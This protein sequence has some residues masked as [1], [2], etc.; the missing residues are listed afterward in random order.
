MRIECLFSSN[1][2][3]GSLR[4]VQFLLLPSPPP[5]DTPGDL[6]FFLQLM[7]YSPPPGHAKR[8]N[9]PPPGLLK[10]TKNWILLCEEWSNC[11]I[12]CHIMHQSIPAAPIP[13]PRANPRALALFLFWVANFRGWGWKKR[14]NAPHPGYR[15]IRF[16]REIHNHNDLSRSRFSV[17]A[18]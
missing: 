12:P 3:L 10:L 15:R 14:A 7:F 11:R 5:G 18:W 17:V 1:M 9:S 6:R 4:M 13:P 16:D 2:S 8:D